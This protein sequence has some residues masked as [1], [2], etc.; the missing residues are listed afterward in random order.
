MAT[1]TNYGWTTPDDTALV[2]DGAAAIRTLGSS[3]DTTTKALNPGTTAGDLDY[4]TTSATKTRVAIGTAG[5]I[6][7]VNSG[8]TAPEW[9]NLPWT[10]WTPTYNDITIG[11]ATVVARYVKLGKTVHFSISIT[12]GSTTSITGGSPSFNLPV[13]AKSANLFLNGNGLDAGIANYWVAGQSDAGSTRVY[14]KVYNVAGTYG[15]PGNASSTTPFTWGTG[16]VYTLFG[17]Y[18][19]N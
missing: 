4:Y 19:E 2:K 1:T 11:N 9:S 8:A 10:T 18:E 6:F 3:V 15:S 14:W 7:A 16:D 13:A 17:T 12:F 5:Q